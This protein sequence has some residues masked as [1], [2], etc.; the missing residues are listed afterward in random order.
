MD[1][2]LIGLAGSALLEQELL[3]GLDII[4]Q[5]ERCGMQHYNDAKLAIFL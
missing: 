4:R 1:L 2:D 5:I 3:Q